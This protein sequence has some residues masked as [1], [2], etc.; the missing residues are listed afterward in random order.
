MPIKAP[1]TLSEMLR[2]K[3]YQNGW[4]QK[5]LASLLGISEAAISGLLSGQRKLNMK[6]AQKLHTKLDIDASFLLTNSI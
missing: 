3:M 2:F 5:Q 4:K 1:K 6:L